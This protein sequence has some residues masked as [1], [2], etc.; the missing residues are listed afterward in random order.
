MTVL[1]MLVSC[2]KLAAA[3]EKCLHD[4]EGSESVIQLWLKITFE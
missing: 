2:F 1:Q 4:D 3:L